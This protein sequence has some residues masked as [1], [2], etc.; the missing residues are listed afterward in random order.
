MPVSSYSK[1]RNLANATQD[2]YHDFVDLIY[3]EDFFFKNLHSWIEN[4]N[5]KRLL[6]LRNVPVGLS[7]IQ[8]SA[9]RFVAQTQ[10]HKLM[11]RLKV[12]SSYD[13]ND[14]S[15][16]LEIDSLEVISFGL[17][18]IYENGQNDDVVLRLE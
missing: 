6:D 16:Y 4:G 14:P 12:E 17:N 3:L 8:E 5:G 13:Q 9:D 15:D 1:E 2:F 10:S 18:Q 11:I 7:S